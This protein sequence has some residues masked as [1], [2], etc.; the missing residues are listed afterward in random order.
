MHRFSTSFNRI[1]PS[2]LCL[3]WLSWGALQLLGQ[4]DSVRQEA[5]WWEGD[6]L[7]FSSD[8]STVLVNP[9]LHF[10]AGV[11]AGQRTYENIRGAKFTAEIDGK[12]KVNGSLEERQGAADDLGSAA[13]AAYAQFDE[14]T[15]FL[16][17]WG[18]S[19]WINRS[20]YA[21]GSSLEFDAS[22]AMGRI[23][24]SG[25]WV[26]QGVH[27]EF[28][29]GIDR[30]HDGPGL[31]SMYWS[32]IAAPMPF[33]HSAFI[34]EKWQVGGM[35]GSSVG[36][37]RGPSG[38]TAESIFS[39][40]SVQNVQINRLTHAHFEP[41]ITW[42]RLRRIPFEG[43]AKR[44]RQ[45]GGVHLDFQRNHW[46]AYGA[47]SINWMA[48]S[49][50]HDEPIYLGELLH[51]SWKNQKMEHAIEWQRFT[52]NAGQSASDGTIMDIPI[53]HAGGPIMSIWGDNVP[54]VSVL[55]SMKGGHDLSGFAIFGRYMEFFNPANSIL[56]G[57]E[58][59]WSNH[60]K[61]RVSLF[62]TKRLI[63]SLSLYLTTQA[64]ITKWHHPYPDGFNERWTRGF[65]ISLQ[66]DFVD[67]RRDNK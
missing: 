32:N 62:V 12:W 10:S 60:P 58:F 65:A 3:A 29:A 47:L 64:F 67:L 57:S 66:T 25:D 44:V 56:T 7:D 39:R 23:E 26:N 31:G 45:W 36:A 51:L 22:R 30:H 9:I 42:Y 20:T 43:E 35:L 11:S 53:A 59:D 4:Q 19:K 16:T 28:Q 2:V 48:L 46:H 21:P 37:E 13:S 52:Q 24:R 14:G 33:V 1:R 27:I 38:S 15:V 5:R 50:S 61:R 18:R 54:T 41:G 6:L 55:S 17:G 40:Q 34:G 63:N 49:S 8:R